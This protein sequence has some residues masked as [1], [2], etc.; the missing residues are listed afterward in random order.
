MVGAVIPV[1]P[2]V[3]TATPGAVEPLLPRSL[4]VLGARLVAARGLRP[5]RSRLSLTP[6]GRSN[7]RRRRACRC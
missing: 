7:Y 2:A 5:S 3:A 1:P 4:T 6:S